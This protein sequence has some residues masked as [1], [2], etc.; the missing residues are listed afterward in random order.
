MANNL[1]LGCADSNHPREPSSN[2]VEYLLD[3]EAAMAID[4]TKDGELRFSE[5]VRRLFRCV[6][7]RD[8]A[9]CTKPVSGVRGRAETAGNQGPEFRP[10]CA[11]ARHFCG[12]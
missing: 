6:S 8:V 11:A 7:T 9:E 12:P 4:E 1:N 10:N 5:Q 3:V 2:E